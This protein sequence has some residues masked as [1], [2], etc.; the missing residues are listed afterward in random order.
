MKQDTAV[1]ELTPS[2][3]K[4]I[5]ALLQGLSVK[6][7]ANEVGVDRS[8]IHRWLKEDAHFRAE[9]NLRK[10]AMLDEVSTRLLRLTV[11]A[12]DALEGAL[13]DSTDGKLAL[14]A[15]RGMGF[16]SGTP[17]AIGPIDPQSIRY[18]DRLDRSVADGNRRLLE[19]AERWAKADSGGAA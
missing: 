14:E 4:A 11:S 8:T 10:Q 16:L 3:V 15:L 1:S 9:L 2:Q 12:V 19:L 7:A 6:A 13:E 17:P 18:Q 5:S